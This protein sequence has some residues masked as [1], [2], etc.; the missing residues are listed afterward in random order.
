VILRRTGGGKVEARTRYRDY[1]GKL[2]QVQARGTSPA[3]ATRALK[4]KLAERIE[5]SP[6]DT[7]LTADSSFTNLVEYW[8]AAAPQPDGPR[9][10]PATSATQPDGAFGR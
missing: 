7:P 5:V 1:D 8:L 10:Q 9:R 3:G 6:L 4:A 2:R